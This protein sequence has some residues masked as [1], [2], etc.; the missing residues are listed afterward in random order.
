MYS[1]I[2]IL[3]YAGGQRIVLTKNEKEIIT[4]PLREVIENTDHFLAT[5]TTNL[6]YQI[7]KVGNNR[8]MMLQIMELLK[9]R[10]RKHK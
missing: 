8:E 2:E 3:P 9:P 10:G 5:T 7:Q 4:S 1:I 6:N